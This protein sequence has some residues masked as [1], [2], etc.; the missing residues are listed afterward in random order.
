MN[1]E[2]KNPFELLLEEIRAVI[3]EEIRSANGNASVVLLTAEQLAVA[4]Q[5]NKA[6]VYEWV[7]AKAIPFYQS[8]RFIRFKLSEVLEAQRKTPA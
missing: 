3:R 1:A 8:G 7:K 6:T 2:N 4:L 5:V